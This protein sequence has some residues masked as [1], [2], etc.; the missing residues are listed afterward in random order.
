MI[1]PNH[2]KSKP[3]YGTSLLKAATILQCLSESDVP[4]GV[5]EIARKTEIGKSTV[6]KLLQTLSHVGYVEKTEQDARFRLGFALIKM[7]HHS[8]SQMDIVQASAPFLAE[9]NEETG[10]T[11]H[12]G[13]LDKDQVVYVNKLESRRTVRMYSRI[14]KTAPLYCT[15]IG[16]ALLSCFSPEA[17]SRYLQSVEL[18]PVTANTLSSPSALRREVE[19]IQKRGY[20][21]DDGEHEEEVRCIAVPLSKHGHTYGAI[22]VSAPRYRMDDNVLHRFLPMLQQCQQ[23]ILQRL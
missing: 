18:L 21:I 10:E 23:H 12:L 11:V 13:V 4:L 9:L 20:A 22:S 8:L 15:G 6:H 16:K 14:G 17:L 19:A 3:S 5:S 2:P 7:A 1:K